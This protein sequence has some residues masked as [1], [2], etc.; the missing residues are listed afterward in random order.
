MALSDLA[1][2]YRTMAALRARLA[3]EPE[4][5]LRGELKALAAAWPGALRELDT[6]PTDEI[7]RRRATLEAVAPGAAPPPWAVWMDGYHTLVRVAIALRAHD[8]AAADRL[9]HEAGLTDDERTLLERPPH[10]RVMAAVF[11]ILAARHA[12]DAATL[13]DALFP[14]R[15]TR[16]R[17]YRSR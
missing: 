10:G 16:P 7:D 3:V 14:S 6:L 5:A 15:G 8:R 17:P 1:E 12:V 2:K 11:Q 13:W 9:A 4:S